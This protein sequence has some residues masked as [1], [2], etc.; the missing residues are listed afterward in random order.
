ML[1]G[2]PF[3]HPL[4]A[5]H[6]PYHQEDKILT[7]DLALCHP[8]TQTARP[9]SLNSIHLF[10][11]MILIAPPLKKHLNA[12]W[13]NEHHN[14]QHVCSLQYEDHQAIYVCVNFIVATIRRDSWIYALPYAPTPVSNL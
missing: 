11:E 14:Q 4:P 9:E 12:I 10:P 8:N 1:H 5:W 13:E 2:L 7:Y 3:T 6:Q